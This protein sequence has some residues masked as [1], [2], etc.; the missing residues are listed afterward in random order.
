MTAAESKPNAGRL[1]YE[2]DVRQTPLYHDGTARP[3]W[4]RL[5]KISQW[6]WE[7]APWPRQAID[8]ATVARASLILFYVNCLKTQ[9]G[10]QNLFAAIAFEVGFLKSRFE[11]RVAYAAVI[12]HRTH[13]RGKVRVAE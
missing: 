3:G 5:D 11:S 10:S 1:A 12:S 8:G 13:A 7:R 4:D 9:S 6:S 2:D